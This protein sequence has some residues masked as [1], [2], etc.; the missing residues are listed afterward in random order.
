MLGFSKRLPVLIYSSETVVWNKRYRRKLQ[1]VQMDI[2]RV[3]LGARS[4][5]KMKNERIMK[6]DVKA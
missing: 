3:L 2:L 1:F 5:Y 6:I 4:I